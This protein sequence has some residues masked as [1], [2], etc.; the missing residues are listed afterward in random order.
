MQDFEGYIEWLK[1]L[2]WINEGECI[3]VVSDMLELAKTYRANG[4]HLDLDELID[5]LQDMVGKTGTL[6]FPTFNWDF[7]KGIDFDYCK[8]PGRTG[9]L[10]KAAMRRSD[11]TRTEHPIYSFAVW[12]AHAAELIDDKSIDSFGKG[13][14]F[15]KMY[16]WD[17]KAIAIGIPAL[18]GVTYVHHVE[19]MVG[20]PY[21]YNKEFTA[22][23][24]DADGKYEKRTYRM[25]VR[26]LVMDPQYND[27]F[28]PLAD[29]M[30]DKGL[31]RTEYY[32]KV[33]CH[34]MRIKDVDDA[35]RRDIIEN[36][37]RNLYTYNHI[38]VK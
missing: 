2:N 37:S 8:T 30:H 6:L 15:E 38:S 23:Y 26:D 16:D 22:G 1:K 33:Q 4:R 34:I 13:T 27:G 14:I 35:V 18:H 19:Q 28:Q 11:F 32:D 7:C 9:A 24:T 21:R 10:S 31:I 17:A 29:Q 36:D 25:Y 5:G 12:G 20:V 3:Y